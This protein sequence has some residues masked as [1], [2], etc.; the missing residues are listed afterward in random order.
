MESPDLKK[1]ISKSD[2]GGHVA[3]GQG[4][5]ASDSKNKTSPVLDGAAE[6][7]TVTECVVRVKQEITENLQEPDE[8]RRNNMSNLIQINA[9]NAELMRRINALIEQKQIEVDINNRQE[10]CN[11]HPSMGESEDSCARTCS[12]FVPRAGG[13]SH[14]KVSRVVNMYGP[15]TNVLNVGNQSPLKP[16]NQETSTLEGIEE[17]LSNME[18]HLSLPGMKKED[19]YRRLK[20]LEE[21]ILFL[22]SLSPEYFT[23]RPPPPKRQKIGPSPSNSSMHMNRDMSLSEIDR[24]IHHLQNVLFKNSSAG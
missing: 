11:I 21:R 6:A 9:S 3:D 2:E 4:F 22:E 18:D 7:D 24:R 5:L 12:I 19:V 23:S 13:K 20:C 14:I 10:F 17:R 15:Q 8:K 16:I 1:S